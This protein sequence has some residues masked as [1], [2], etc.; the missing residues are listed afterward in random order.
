MNS[1]QQPK[2]QLLESFKLSRSCNNSAKHTNL[3]GLPLRIILVAQKQPLCGNFMRHLIYI[4][5]LLVLGCDGQTNHK[6]YKFSSIGW[7]V[8]VPS[9]LKIIDSL[10]LNKINSDGERLVQDAYNTNTKIPAPHSLI[11]FKKGED[12]V[13]VCNTTPFDTT[14]DGNWN[15]HF[16]FLKELAFKTLQNSTQDIKNVQIDTSSSIETIDNKLMNTFSLKVIVPN[17]KNVTMNLLS[18]L[19]N[20]FDVG[21]TIVSQDE[22]IKNRFY[23]I[24]RTSKFD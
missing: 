7:T 16:Q 2:I 1:V 23:E 19:R 14:K 12:N 20:G 13:F 3:D 15:E 10:T 8:E 4:V 17:Q 6:T 9:D 5:A 24:L 21:F 22:K 11:S 18:I